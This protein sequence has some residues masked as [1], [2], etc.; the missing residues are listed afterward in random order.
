MNIG[1][2]GFGGR[3][4]YWD[5]R[6]EGQAYNAKISQQ[7]GSHYLKA[8]IEHRRGYGVSFVG[9]TSNFFFPT[10]LTAETFTSPG[11]QAQRLRVCDFL[12]GAL[13]GQSQMIGGPAPDPHDEFWGMFFQDDWKVNRWLTLNLGLRNEYE[14]AWHDPG[15]NMSRGLDLSAPI[16]EMQA[17]PPQFPAAGSCPGRQRIL[18]VQW[19]V[20]LDRRQPSGNVESTE[21]CACAQSSEL[22]SESTIKTAL[23][24]GYARYYHS[25]GD[26]SRSG[27]GLGIRDRK[28]PGAAVLRSQRLSEYAR[29]AAGHSA[30][31]LLRIRSLR[32]TR[33][34]RS[35]ERRPVR[36]W[37]GA[38][39]RCFGIRRIS[40][41]R[42]MT[43]ST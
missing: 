25:D 20:E 7:R 22:R 40:R 8:G 15:H 16:P 32:A 30:A 1:G 4:F 35:V 11:H 36:T 18:Q 9:N 12:L 6:P 27:A 26:E 28:L 38:A 5:Q 39:L 2:T 19:P 23:R 34:S 29:A 3:G 37:D 24:L 31:N 33:S 10:E 13:D 14:T 41:S 17:N 42:P 43:A 21:A